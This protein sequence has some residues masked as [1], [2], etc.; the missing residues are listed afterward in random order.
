M[1]SGAE[2]TRVHIDESENKEAQK[3]M[4]A[5]AEIWNHFEKI[6][7]DGVVQKAKCHYC[8]TNIA[9]HP[10]FNGTSA[11]RKHFHVCKCNPHKNIGDDKQDVQQVNH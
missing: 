11:L 5:R 10:I 6:K 3:L 9:A 1:S 4:A 2:E 7:V 8:K